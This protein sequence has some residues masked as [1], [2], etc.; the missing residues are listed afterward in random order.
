MSDTEIEAGDIVSGLEPDKHVQVR[1]VVP[2]G[3]KTLVE[4]VAVTSRREIRRPLSTADLAR[5]TK[6]RGSSRPGRRSRRGYCPWPED[7]GRLSSSPGCH[8]GDLG[9]RTLSLNSKS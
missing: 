5:L 7:S 8:I 6:V 1:R 2:F 9:S 4:G 3:G